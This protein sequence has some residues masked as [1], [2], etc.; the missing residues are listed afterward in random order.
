MSLHGS[1]RT[2]CPTFTEQVWFSSP[3]LAA[4]CLP[5]Y[6]HAM[7]TCADI[8]DDDDDR[9]KG[10]HFGAE[11]VDLERFPFDN[12]LLSRFPSALAR[13]LKVLPLSS[14]E[15]AVTVAIG[16]PSDLDRIDRLHHELKKQVEVRIAES[17][18]LSAFVA[19]FFPE[20]GA[21][22]ND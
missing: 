3:R 21:E 6:S 8:P 13:E 20:T 7:P 12:E 22:S 19:R 9:R 11:C 14:D 2:V 5:W 15:D 17:G 16:D 10:A 18:Q 1:L 4:A